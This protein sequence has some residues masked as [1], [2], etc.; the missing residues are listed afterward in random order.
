MSELENFGNWVP[1]GHLQEI[2][3]ATDESKTVQIG[4][5]IKLAFQEAL[6]SLLRQYTNLFALAT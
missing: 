1:K 3:L 6:I 2:L 4:V 5:D